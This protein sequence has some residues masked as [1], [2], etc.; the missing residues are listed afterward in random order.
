ML[1]SF[2]CVSTHCVLKHDSCS[3]L[4]KFSFFTVNFLVSFYF[5][6][7]Q[8]DYYELM[9]PQHFL[10]VKHKI[11]FSDN[12]FFCLPVQLHI[13][14]NFRLFQPKPLFQ[15]LC[16][17]LKTHPQFLTGSYQCPDSLFQSLL[18]SLFPSSVLRFI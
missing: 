2:L 17:F 7:T 16:C 13:P 1:A 10:F 11:I 18:Y 3:S 6:L 12:C 9:I 4:V 5:P 14:L 8:W 15:L